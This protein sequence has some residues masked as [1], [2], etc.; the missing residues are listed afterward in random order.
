M[1]NDYLRLILQSAH[2]EADVADKEIQ[3]ILMEFLS[4]RNSRNNPSDSHSRIRNIDNLTDMGFNLTRFSPIPTI[5][6]TVP[7]TPVGSGIVTPIPTSTLRPSGGSCLNSLDPIPDRQHHHVP[8]LYNSYDA[9]RSV[10]DA[11]RLFDFQRPSGL[12]SGPESLETDDS[13]L[14]FEQP[15][16]IQEKFHSEIK[17]QIQHPSS[18]TQTILVNMTRGTAGRQTSPPRIPSTQNG[19]QT[20]STGNNPPQPNT[21]KGGK[22]KSSQGKQTG[23]QPQPSTS[24]S[25]T[26]SQSAFQSRNLGMVRPHIQY[27]SCGEYDCFRK[28]CHYDNFCSRC[29]SRSH[30][31]HMCQVPLNTGNNPICVYCGSSQHTLSNCTS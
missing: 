26:N 21:G 20:M 2:A 9:D 28:D 8:N 12:P 3:I 25:G 24:G 31:T 11:P 19:T 15:D 10:S 7:Q 29:R 22:K 13:M 23:L 18:T 17:V 5:S 1:E 6:N 27:S 14:T 4:E 30:A 16:T